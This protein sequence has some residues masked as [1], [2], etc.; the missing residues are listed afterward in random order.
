MKRITNPERQADMARIC[1]TTG[2][3]MALDVQTTGNQGVCHYC[4]KWVSLDKLRRWTPAAL[5]L[6]NSDAEK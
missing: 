5:K 2:H 4:G 6:A 1:K 3:L